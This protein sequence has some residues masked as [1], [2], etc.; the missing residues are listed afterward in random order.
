VSDSD[1]AHCDSSLRRPCTPSVHLGEHAPP[2]HDHQTVVKTSVN[3]GG[4]SFSLLPLG[5]GTHGPPVH[6]DARWLRGGRVL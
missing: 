2:H 1:G 3:G 4:L 5:N 6:H